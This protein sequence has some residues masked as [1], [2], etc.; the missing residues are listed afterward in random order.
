MNLGVKGD[1]KQEIFN[2]VNE[3]VRAL[4]R[5]FPSVVKDGQV[6]FEAL[7]EELGQF[8]EVGPEKY[9]L[10]WSGKQNAKKLAQQ[11]IVGKTLKY[12]PEDILEKAKR[13]INAIQ[14]NSLITVS[15]MIL[16]SLL[17]LEISAIVSQKIYINKEA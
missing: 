10:T 5:L 14:G 15:L 9:G 13:F 12:I 4:E 8:E 1:L 7:K 16:V 17:I 3:N 11:D 2:E 6:D